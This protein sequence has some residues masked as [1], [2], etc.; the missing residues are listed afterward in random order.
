MRNIALVGLALAGITF[1]QSSTG[2][3]TFTR[4]VKNMMGEDLGQVHTKSKY[5]ASNGLA[6]RVTNQ[7]VEGTIKLLHSRGFGGTWLIYGDGSTFNVPY[8]PWYCEMGQGFDKVVEIQVRINAN[9]P[10][11]DRNSIAWLEE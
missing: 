6:L 2:Q 4:L 11:G 3:Q 9:N 10:V 7:E 8:F 1:A 5:V